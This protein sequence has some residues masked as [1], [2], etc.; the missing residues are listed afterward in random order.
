MF[1][2]LNTIVGIG[3]L[4]CWI[5]EVVTAFKKDDGP[6]MGILSIVCCC[7]I[8]GL[9]IGWI[10]CKKWGIQ[11]LMLVYTIAF[12]LNMILSGIAQKEMLEMFQ[13][14]GPQ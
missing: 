7:T 2:A 12:V 8:G 11:N 4:V 3:V 6:L 10:N 14:N 13:M 1:V 5:M 9:V